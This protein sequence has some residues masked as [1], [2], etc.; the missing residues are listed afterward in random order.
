MANNSQTVSRFGGLVCVVIASVSALAA[1]NFSEKFNHNMLLDITTFIISFVV[2]VLAYGLVSKFLAGVI[3]DLNGAADGQ[4]AVPAL[5]V[6]VVSAASEEVI[7][8]TEP[9]T[10]RPDLIRSSLD[11][12]EDM[13]AEAQRKDAQRR[14]DTLQAIHDYVMRKLADRLSKKSLAALLANIERLAFNVSDEYE[15]L[16]SDMEKKLK[17]PDLRHLSWNIGERL[18]I[19]H[20]ERAVFIKASFPVELQNASIEY[21]EANLRDTV[22][23]YIRIDVPDEGDYRFHDEAETELKIAV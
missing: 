19:P 21:L 12:Y 20:R 1:Y 23:S 11:K 13:L 7:P 18:G 6:T 4:T 15:P 16:R 9:A 8:P 5:A 22:P 17:S 3:G 10:S 2:L 14:L